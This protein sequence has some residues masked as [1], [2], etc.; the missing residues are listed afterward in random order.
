[1]SNLTNSTSGVSPKN[2]N[3]NVTINEK[4]CGIIKNEAV[5][6][7]ASWRT[8]NDNL[9]NVG[10]CYNTRTYIVDKAHGI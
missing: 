8:F 3:S 7:S 10:D 1:M 2:C 4:G 5:P 9:P 6:V